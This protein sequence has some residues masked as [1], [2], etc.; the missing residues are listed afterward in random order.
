VDGVL[1]QG[2]AEIRDALP[3][4]LDAAKAAT[5]RGRTSG[6]SAPGP[7]P[8]S[9][10]P[11][12]PVAV[13]AR[14]AVFPVAAAGLLD[15]VNPCAFTTLIFLLASLALAGRGRIEILVI[16]AGFSL[17]VFVTYFLIGLGFLAALRAAV[18]VPIVS[19]I[20][21][22][23]L[24]AVLAGCAALSLYD[25]NLIRRGRPG[26]MILQLPMALKRRIHASI[27]SRVRTA[28]I[29]ASSLVLGFLVSVFE[30]ACTGQV[31]VPTL[32]WLAR[33]GDR[34]RAIGLLLLYNTA[35]IVPLLVVFGASWA[36][37]GSAGLASLFRAH[38][39]KVKLGLAA[40]FIGLAVLTLV[41]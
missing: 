33:T 10:P 3:A 15:G 16:G 40:V 31:Y 27:R 32:A 19:V 41:G 35:F 34:G 21:R 37:V 28:A 11:G 18:A 39:G 13:S 6:G 36:G 26:D 29:A 12:S 2:D 23:I 8:A 22:W 25:Y 14:L 30:F 20:L 5:D 24:V 9:G 4:V 1:L 7:A 17:S 38:A